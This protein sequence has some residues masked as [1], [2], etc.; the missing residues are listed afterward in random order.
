MKLKTRIGIFILSLIFCSCKPSDS[1]LLS[2]QSIEF[3]GKEREYYIYKPQNFDSKNS[4]WLVVAVHGGG[5]NGKKSFLI[6]GIR[7]QVEMLG[8]NAIVVSPSF[9]NTDF[10]A[11]RFPILGEGGFLKSVIEEL[12]GDFILHE[13]IILVGYSRGGQIYHMFSLNKNL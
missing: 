11:S 2:H 7:D 1:K 12:H 8:L 6:D 9:S 4:N 13:N 3:E 10:L 5:G